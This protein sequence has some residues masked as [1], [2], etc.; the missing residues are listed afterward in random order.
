VD[1]A[2]RAECAR[3][4]RAGLDLSAGEALQKDDECDEAQRIQDAILDEVEIRIQ[5]QE[6]RP[7]V[8]EPALDLVELLRLRAQPRNPGSEMMS[9]LER[10]CTVRPRNFRW[11]A[12]RAGSPR[13]S[14]RNP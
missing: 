10:N 2:Q 11:H 12:L 3:R 4:E 8:E 6:V 9:L 5:V 14:V 13:T 1:A 7:S